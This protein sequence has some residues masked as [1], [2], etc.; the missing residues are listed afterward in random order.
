VTKRRTAKLVFVVGF[1]V[2]LLDGAAAIWLGQLSG[3][4]ALIV[5]GLLLVGAAAAL[6]VAWRKWMDALDAVDD[7]RRDLR[8]EIGRLREAAEDARTGRWRG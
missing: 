7:A 4:P 1:A 8:A 2:L 3:R 5:V 6:V